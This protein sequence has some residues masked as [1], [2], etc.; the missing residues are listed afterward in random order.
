LKPPGIERLKLNC[1]KTLSN[2]AFKFNSRR[3][4]V[5]D[6]DEGGDWEEVDEAGGALITSTRAGIRS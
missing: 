1:D 5:V 3:Y 2:F 6:E 4:N